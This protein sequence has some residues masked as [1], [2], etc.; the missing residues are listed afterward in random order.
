MFDLRKKKFVPPEFEAFVE[1]EGD[2]WQ[3]SLIAHGVQ[4]GGAVF[5][6]DGTGAAF[7]LAKQVADD[8]IQTKGGMGER[9][10]TI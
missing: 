3:V 4:V 2:G 6:D 7:D 5:P 10:A 9:S 1:D 8:W